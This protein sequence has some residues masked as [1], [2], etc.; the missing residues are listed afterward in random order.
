MQ[1]NKMIELVTEMKN[2]QD[3]AYENRHLIKAVGHY[4]I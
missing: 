4:R 1:T 3:F 2:R